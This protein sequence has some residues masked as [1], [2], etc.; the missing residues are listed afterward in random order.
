LKL[1]QEPTFQ[2]VKEELEKTMNKK[3]WNEVVFCGFGEPLERLDLVL[4][5]TRWIK[6]NF[7]KKVRVDTNGQCYLLNNGIDVIKELK[8]VGID[9]VRVSL[10]AHDKENYNKVCKPKFKNA[11]EKIFEFIKRA[12][13]E[14]IE[15]EV[16][17]VTIP[18]V[19]LMKTRELVEK[20]GAKF[21]IREYIQ[22]FW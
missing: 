17:A 15:T 2:N 13:E 4:G 7:R 10:N 1:E 22:F 12:V 6:N 20:M 18:E 21:I 8:E 5:V 9:K 3:N 16:T 19:D 11:Y 14:G